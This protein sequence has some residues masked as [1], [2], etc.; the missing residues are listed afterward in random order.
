MK[1]T[2]DNLTVSRWVAVGVFCTCTM[3]LT[4]NWWIVGLAF[5]GVHVIYDLLAVLSGIGVSDD[6]T[7]VRP[8]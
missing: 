8:S 1:L 6:E 3:G 7:P 5:G 2:W 4:L